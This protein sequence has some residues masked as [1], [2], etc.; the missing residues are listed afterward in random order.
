MFRRLE[1]Q[2]EDTLMNW[3]RERGLLAL[4]LNTIGNRGYPDRIFFIL[5]GRPLLI[6]LKR[7]G[8]KPTKLQLYVHQQ[9]RRLGYDVQVHDNPEDAKRAVTAAVEAAQVPAKKSG[10]RS[11]A[12]RK[13]P[14]ARS[15]NG[16]DIDYS[17]APYGAPQSKSNAG[18]AG[19]RSATRLPAGLAR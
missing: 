16:K 17:E 18:R 4:K 5:G 14:A 8:A 10:V 9:L 13:R 2:D 12:V 1:K 15:R 11:E 6:E 7:K 3:A 19:N